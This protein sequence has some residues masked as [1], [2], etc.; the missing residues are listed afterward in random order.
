[1]RAK[2]T[3]T[4]MRFGALAGHQLVLNAANGDDL[5]GTGALEGD[6]AVVVALTE[7]C[8]GV[9]DKRPLIVADIAALSIEMGLGKHSGPA[10]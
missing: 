9:G 7:E 6:A 10:M 2:M 3:A 8:Q 4:Q 5:L 1:M